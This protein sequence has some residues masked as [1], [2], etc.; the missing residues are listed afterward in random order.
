MQVDFPT[1]LAAWKEDWAQ[2][3]V[4]WQPNAIYWRRFSGNIRRLA[5]ENF[6]DATEVEYAATCLL[7]ALRVFMARAPRDVH[8]RR[9]LIWLAVLTSVLR[10]DASDA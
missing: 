9:L 4:E 2:P 10:E 8:R 7:R 5:R 1:E 3:R 6:P